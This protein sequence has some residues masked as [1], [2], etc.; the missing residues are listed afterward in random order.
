M[1]NV[2]QLNIIDRSSLI[3][4]NLE[5]CTNF[6]LDTTMKIQNRDGSWIRFLDKI[7]VMGIPLINL[8]IVIIW[9]YFERLHC[10]E[11]PTLFFVVTNR[12]FSIL[13]KIKMFED[14]RTVQLA[15]WAIPPA[16]AG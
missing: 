7:V 8:G 15:L 14:Q 10:A 4:K 11:L 2:C 6:G 1:A 12:T 3:P 13:D 16:G 9:I 5:H